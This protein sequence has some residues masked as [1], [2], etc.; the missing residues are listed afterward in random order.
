[1]QAYL[2]LMRRAN[3]FAV[4]VG[5]ETPDPEALRATFSYHPAYYHFG[6]D[7]T[8]LVDFGPQN[9]RGFRALK[10]W[11]TLQ[12]VGRE[13]CVRMIRDDIRLA[14]SVWDAVRV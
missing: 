2:D 11:L 3:F 7:V 8:N 5:V 14:R 9:S 10:V 6:S 12:Q 1:M 4:F 13:G